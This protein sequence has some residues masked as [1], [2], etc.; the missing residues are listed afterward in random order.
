M[1]IKCAYEE[2]EH[3]ASAFIL[4]KQGFPCSS[5][6][7]LL[8]AKGD[9]FNTRRLDNHRLKGTVVSICWRLGNGIHHLLAGNNSPKNR[10]VGWQGA[11][12]VHNEKLAAI[13]VWTSVGHGDNARHIT[14]LV[15]WRSRIDFIFKLAAESRLSPGTSAGRITALDHKAANDAVDVTLV[16]SH[17]WP[18]A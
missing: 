10:I 13:C 6:L 17:D 12:F 1:R 16:Y 15:K 4:E 3:D 2:A 5:R 11:L 9:L 7:C 14:C 8:L 18:V